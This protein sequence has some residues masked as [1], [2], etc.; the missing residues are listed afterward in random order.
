MQSLPLNEVHFLVKSVCP[1]LLMMKKE[2]QHDES[3]GLPSRFFMCL[4]G[5]S[6]TQ[7]VKYHIAVQTIYGGILTI[8]SEI[9]RFLGWIIHCLSILFLYTSLNAVKEVVV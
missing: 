7:S 1:F 6:S 4:C 5:L 3:A 8:P 2:A 9:E